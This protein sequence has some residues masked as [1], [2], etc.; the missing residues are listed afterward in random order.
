MHGLPG[1]GLA[2]VRRCQLE[3]ARVERLRSKTDAMAGAGGHHGA[4]S[5]H[6]PYSSGMPRQP[7]SAIRLRV[8]A[9]IGLKP[10]LFKKARTRSSSVSVEILTAGSGLFDR[11]FNELVDVRFMIQ[12]DIVY[13][14]AQG[15]RKAHLEE[16]FLFDES[17][18]MIQS[19]KM[20]PPMGSVISQNTNFSRFPSQHQS[21]D[22][23]HNFPANG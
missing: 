11:C 2:P 13:G 14:I 17:S 1:T 12:L 7:A 21:N 8:A 15:F 22:K 4:S 9:V 6:A 16:P 19:I 5:L 10:S 20:R 23:T 3:D 18:S